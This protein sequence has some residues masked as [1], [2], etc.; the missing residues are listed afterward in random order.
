M[1]DRDSM[2]RGWDACWNDGPVSPPWS[3]VFEHLT[4]AQAAT[5]P[6]PGRHSVWQLLEHMVFWRHATISHLAG[7]PPSAEDV[8]R[9][10]WAGPSS[11]ASPS[12]SDWADA[13][14]RFAA[15]QSAVRDAMRDERHPTEAFR[16]LF[17]H[18]AYH[19]GQVALTRQLVGAPPIRTGAESP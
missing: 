13:R 4:A 5:P 1:S 8:A 10:E 6:A 14:A 3:L 11:P 19:C 16:G 17:L 7:R 18:D 15:S 9:H 2:I 12:E